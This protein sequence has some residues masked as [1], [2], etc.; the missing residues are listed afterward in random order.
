MRSDSE[1]TRS[2]TKGAVFSFV[3]EFEG[4]VNLS[5]ASSTPVSRRGLGPESSLGDND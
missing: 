5:I 2:P 3:G 4:P 1:I